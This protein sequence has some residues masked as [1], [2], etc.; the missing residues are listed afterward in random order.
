MIRYSEKQI[1]RIKRKLADAPRVETIE[2]GTIKRIAEEEGIPADTLYSIYH[3]NRHADVAPAPAAVC[4]MA[5]GRTGR[6]LCPLRR[7][8]GTSD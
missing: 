4:S 8:E 2:R 5:G 1:A 7:C 6:A 3:G